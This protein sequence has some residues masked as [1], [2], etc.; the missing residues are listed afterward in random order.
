ML[1]TTEPPLQTL[2][3]EFESHGRFPDV[4]ILVQ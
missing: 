4:Q 1:L 3:L 2:E